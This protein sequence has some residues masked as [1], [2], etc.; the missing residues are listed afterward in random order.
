[1]PRMNMVIFLH[2][3]AIIISYF[4]IKIISRIKNISKCSELNA[5][6]ITIIKNLSFNVMIKTIKSMS[7]SVL[8]DCCKDLTD[9][10]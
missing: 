2:V 3:S 5:I 4:I 1:M 8:Y 10:H 9:D 7:L 6:S